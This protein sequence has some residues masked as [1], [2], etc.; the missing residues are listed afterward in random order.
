[1][2]ERPV[3]DVHNDFIIEGVDS[4]NEPWTREERQ[5]LADFMIAEWTRF[6]ERED[7]Q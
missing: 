5:E 4:S 7:S 3:R 2:G 1:M 6:K